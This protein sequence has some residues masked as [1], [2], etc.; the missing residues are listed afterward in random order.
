MGRRPRIR[1]N[2][3]LAKAHA[4]G[5]PVVV[6][7]PV[8][9][10]TFGAIN[11]SWAPLWPVHFHL[12]EDAAEQ[13]PGLHVRVSEIEPGPSRSRY[14][15]DVELL[16]DAYEICN[17]MVSHSVRAVQ[18]LAQDI[19]TQQRGALSGVTSAERI[20]EAA[21]L[22]ST[23]DYSATPEYSGFGEI[24]GIRDALEHPS[25]ENVYQD[26]DWHRVPLAWTISDR[27]LL[28]WARFRSWFTQLADDWKKFKISRPPEP[29][30]L[31][32]ITRGIESTLDVKKPP[33]R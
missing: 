12:A 33:K 29:A 18:H 7:Q 2:P 19:E 26:T 3:A 10:S 11:Y 21:K 25:K 31:T 27:S 23:K 16:R 32:V 13:L 5:T 15:D 6:V 4:A 24:V 28:A 17:A 14:I 8:E 1:G 30:T 9:H 22:F 20:R